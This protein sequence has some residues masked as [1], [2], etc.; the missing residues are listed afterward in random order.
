MNRT[1]RKESTDEITRYKDIDL[2]S[3]SAVMPS[4]SVLQ[5]TVQVHEKPLSQSWLPSSETGSIPVVP[6][7]SMLFVDSLEKTVAAISGHGTGFPLQLYDF[8]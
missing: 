4:A 2:L 6:K 1:F 8:H 7:G 3:N 5:G